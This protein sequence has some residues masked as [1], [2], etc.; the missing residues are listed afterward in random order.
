MTL[1][2]FEQICQGLAPTFVGSLSDSAGR[3]PVYIICFTVYIGANIA[4]ARQHSYPALLILRAVQ[5]SGSSGT[6]ALVSAVAADLVTSSER[7]KYIGLASLGMIMGPTLGPIIGGLLSEYLGWRSIFW[8]LAISASAIFV[9]MLLFYPE[10]CRNVVGDGSVPPPPWNG[11]YLN[12]RDKK[13]W[14]VRDHSSDDDHIRTPRCSFSPKRRSSSNNNRIR[15]PNPC[16]AL[17]ILFE[18][19]TG[20]ILLCNGTMYA[21]YYFMMSSVPSQ[22]SDIYGVSDLNVGLIFIAPGSGT[23]MGAWLNG[24]LL[25]WNF[26]RL[27]AQQQQQQH[28]GLR[29]TVAINGDVGGGGSKKQNLD[30]FPIE[31]ARLQIALPMLVGVLFQTIS[32]PIFFPPPSAPA[33]LVGSCFFTRKRLTPIQNRSWNSTSAPSA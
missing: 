5:S 28:E 26:R 4:L 2:P 15:T 24:H 25:D 11:S 30:H 9:P 13:A 1:K 32:L 18:L 27:A 22:F 3:R 7:G 33:A 17:R 23:L 12:Y 19:P 10:T 29:I 8:F 16:T 6:I 20:L 31:R 14:G 21:G